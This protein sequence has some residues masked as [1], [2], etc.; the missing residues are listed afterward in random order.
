MG[1]KLQ[2]LKLK[3]EIKM[4]NVHDRVMFIKNG[5]KIVGKIVD[6]FYS[7]D[8]TIN[9]LVKDLNGEPHAVPEESLKYDDM[10]E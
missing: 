5:I 9:F 3:G 6:I 10:R 2:T 4:F 7:Y 1:V 8:R